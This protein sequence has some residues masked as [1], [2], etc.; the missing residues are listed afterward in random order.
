MSMKTKIYINLFNI[1]VENSGGM[2]KTRILGIRNNSRGIVNYEPS[3]KALS[4]SLYYCAFSIGNK[5]GLPPP[6]ALLPS[7]SFILCHSGYWYNLGR[8][9][10]IVSRKVLWSSVYSGT[11]SVGTF[12]L[13]AGV[14]GD[15]VPLIFRVDNIIRKNVKGL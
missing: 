8:M 6:G 15:S 11:P 5:R 3:S 14:K 4:P 13:N 9:V 10:E 1:Q 2:P 7:N 12:N